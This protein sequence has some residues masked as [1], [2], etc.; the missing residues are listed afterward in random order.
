MYIT[1]FATKNHSFQNTNS[2]HLEDTSLL[3]IAPHYENHERWLLL[4]QSTLK[5]KKL[6]LYSISKRQNNIY[7]YVCSYD[8]KLVYCSLNQKLTSTS[9]ICSAVH[10]EIFYSRGS[11]ECSAS[12]FSHSISRSVL[13]KC[14]IGS[15]F[16]WF[17]DFIIVRILK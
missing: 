4:P 13:C 10:W 16:M 2:I 6:T 15:I 8:N 1:F 3:I 5:N 14:I 11:Q 9:S 17:I 7:K 12:N